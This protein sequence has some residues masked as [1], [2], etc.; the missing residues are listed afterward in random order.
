M[1]KLTL[2][3]LLAY[4]TLMGFGQG[5]TADV[6]DTTLMLSDSTLII[7]TT[8]TPILT[9]IDTDTGIDSLPPDEMIR[10][11][12]TFASLTLPAID[13]GN[14][15]KRALLYY[16][17]QYADECYRDSSITTYHRSP[18]MWDLATGT[19]MGNLCFMTGYNGQCGNSNHWHDKWI[20][21]DPTFPGF[22]KWLKKE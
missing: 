4:I 5:T 1:K 21:K 14:I 3:I 17:D 15:V 8:T 11:K 2:L 7:T 20:H 6:Q 16:W 19:A 13:P 22:I 18:M 9:L 12:P 10:F